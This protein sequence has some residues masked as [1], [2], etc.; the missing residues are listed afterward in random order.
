ML[1]TIGHLVNLNVMR[2]RSERVWGHWPSSWEFN[3]RIHPS[4]KLFAALLLS[5][6]AAGPR[7]RSGGKK[8]GRQGDHHTKVE[9][10]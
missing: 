1:K 9:S 3:E 7:W 2:P 10:P 5:S 6:S 8:E 4:S